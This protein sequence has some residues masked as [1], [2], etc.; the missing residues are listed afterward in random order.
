[1][2]EID[3]VSGRAAEPGRRRRDPI[4][5]GIRLF[6]SCSSVV[7]ARLSARAGGAS[8]G[9]GPSGIS[10]PKRGEIQDQQRSQ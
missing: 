2:E 7:A 8:A 6:F 3:A 9:P 1:M 5:G 4:G 10:E